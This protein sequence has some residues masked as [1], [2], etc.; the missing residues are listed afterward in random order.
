MIGD[1]IELLA[2]KW[3]TFLLRGLIAISLAVFAFM[4]PATMSTA[5]VYIVASFFILSGLLTLFS[6]ISLT[7]VGNWWLLIIFGIGQGALGILM[8]A[9]PGAGPLAL[10]YLVAIWAFSTGLMEIASAFAFRDFIKNE[11]SQSKTRQLLRHGSHSSERRAAS[12]V[13]PSDALWIF[14]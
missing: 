1:T 14:K 9:K 5:L 2:S 3:W 7:G 4:A 10:A 13:L 11:F 12:D 6:G 8:L